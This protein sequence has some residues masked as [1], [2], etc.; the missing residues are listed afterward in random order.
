MKANM[1]GAALGVLL[2]A[3][4]SFNSVRTKINTE[5]VVKVEVV[6]IVKEVPVEVVIEKYISECKSFDESFRIHRELLGKS[7]TF[8]WKGQEYNLYHKEE[9][10]WEQ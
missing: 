3:I 6:E 1:I 2:I 7:G 10:K 9:I 8:F 4:I 5:E